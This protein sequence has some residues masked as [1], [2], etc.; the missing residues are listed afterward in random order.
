MLAL[1]VVEHGQVVQAL[2]HIDMIGTD[3][4]L[5]YLQGLLGHD[6]GRSGPFRFVSTGT[7]GTGTG[8]LGGSRFTF[9]FG[10]N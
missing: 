4:P 3:V 6:D 9:T 7:R 10:K 2:G 5:G 8:D 1:G